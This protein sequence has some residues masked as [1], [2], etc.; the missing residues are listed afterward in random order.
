M[1]EAILGTVDRRVLIALLTIG[2]ELNSSV[3]K[4]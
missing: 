3:H 4:V 1:D 2:A